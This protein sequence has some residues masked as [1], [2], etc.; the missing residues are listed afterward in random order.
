MEGQVSAS[1]VTLVLNPTTNEFN[2]VQKK[3]VLYLKTIVIV[4]IS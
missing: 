2:P 1:T 3:R 4:S